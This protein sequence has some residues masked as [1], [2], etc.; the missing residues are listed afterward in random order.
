MGHGTLEAFLP[1]LEQTAGNL[2]ALFR[3]WIAL[4][5]LP[6][7]DGSR[8]RLFQ[9]TQLRF[10]WQTPTTTALVRKVR[11]VQ[12]ARREFKNIQQPS[13]AHCVP[14]ASHEPITCGRTSGPIRTRGPSY[15]RYA[16]KLSLASMIANVTKAYIP[17]RR[18]LCAKVI[19]RA[20][21]SGVAVGDLPGRT[22]W[23]GISALKRG[24]S[25]SS[26]SSMR[27]CWNA[28]GSGTSSGCSRRMHRGWSCR[29]LA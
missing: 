16:V 20:V 18:S 11:A 24:A 17:A 8:L 23:V 1:I 15:V 9:T 26:L 25:A 21:A 3:H 2:R 5:Y 22:P 6:I 27:R 10:A 4:E 19:S 13:N 28:S 29:H 14:N 7:E 12:A